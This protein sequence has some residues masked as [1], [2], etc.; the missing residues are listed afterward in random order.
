MTAANFGKD[1]KGTV[2]DRKFEGGMAAGGV[3]LVVAK[4]QPIIGSQVGIGGHMNLKKIMQAA[5]RLRYHPLSETN[6][7]HYTMT[8]FRARRF[9]TESAD[10]AS[11]GHNAFRFTLHWVQFIA[12]GLHD[13]NIG[14]V[15]FMMN[16]DG[17]FQSTVYLPTIEIEVQLNEDYSYTNGRCVVDIWKMHNQ[18]MGAC[19][20]E[21]N[22]IDYMLLTEVAQKQVTEM[23]C[24]LM[25][26]VMP[27]VVRTVKRSKILTW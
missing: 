19:S 18:M 14:P 1:R 15:G 23:A 24:R 11:I 20:Y 9:I 21:R 22:F 17:K 13:M 27:L 16:L 5:H 26:D 4:L 3:N 10:V 2:I 25:D 8:G 6:P 12:N 7:I